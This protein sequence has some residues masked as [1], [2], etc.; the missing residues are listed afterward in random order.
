MFLNEVCLIWKS[1]W[2]SLKPQT[3]DKWESRK[4]E[5]LHGLLMKS[6]V[7]YP[8]VSSPATSSRTKLFRGKGLWGW[9]STK[10]ADLGISYIY[11]GLIRLVPVL[12]RVWAAYVVFGFQHSALQMPVGYSHTHLSLFSVAPAQFRGDYLLSTTTPALPYLL[13]HM[14]LS[15]SMTVLTV[16]PPPD[17]HHDSVPTLLCHHE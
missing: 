4:A 13:I 8:I 6:S 14:S 15:L 9:C 12:R 11:S 7:L 16:T 2:K 3:R 10:N 5:Q 17:S 1:V